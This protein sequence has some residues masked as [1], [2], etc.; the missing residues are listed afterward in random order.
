MN[1]PEP[2]SVVL[3]LNRLSAAPIEKKIDKIVRN[4]ETKPRP[5]AQ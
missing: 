3:I 4:L 5:G 1:V 2:T